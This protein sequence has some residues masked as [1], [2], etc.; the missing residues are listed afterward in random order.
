MEKFSDSISENELLLMRYYNDSL[1]KIK[2]QLLDAAVTGNDTAHLKKLQENV[3]NELIKLN[4]KFQWFSKDTTSKT[5]KKGIKQQETSFR[6]LHIKFTPV[7]ASTYTQFAGIHKQAVK[8]LAINTY[9]PLKRVVDVI[10][11][12][13]IE[14]F[15]RTN[16]N[17]T[18]AILKKLLKFFPDSEDLRSTGLASIQ[19][20]VTGNTTWQRAIREFQET[21]MKEEIFKVP[22]YKKD[23]TLH[24]MVNMADYA[25]LVA[26]T[27]SAEAYRKG[28][29]NA[30]LEAFD[31]GDLVQVNGHSSFPNS[32]CLPFE[33]A[34]LSLTGKTKGYTTL[35]EAKAQGLFHP[36]CIHHFGVTR[37]VI[38]EYDAIEAGKNQGTVLKEIDKPPTAKR[39]KQEAEGNQKWNMKD[40]LATYTGNDELL[41]KAFK[42]AT[43]D[44]EMAEVLANVNKLPAVKIIN[45]RGK[46]YYD[47][48]RSAISAKDEITFLH[49]FG[50]SL[51]YGIIKASTKGYGSFSKKLES[52]VDKHR[53]KRM[54]NF[55]EAVANKFREVKRTAASKYGVEAY[56]HIKEE[57]WNA[58][59]DIFDALTNGNMFGKDFSIAGHGAKY[60][61]MTG[62]KE[63]EI[64]AQYVRLRMNNCT[65]ALSFLKE[66]V[67]DLLK[68]LDESFTLYVKELKKL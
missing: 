30:I 52:V 18:Q 45:D 36:N 56:K 49:E 62:M 54:N 37:A 64:F 59:S 11:R 55:P 5:Y 48:I 26:R 31:E 58:V 10:G 27:T 43:I 20:V 57:G 14:Y 2:K 22:Y 67:P 42:L 61:R 38:A 65:E 46:G 53:I 17:D 9:K 24:S 6:Q 12:D 25:E 3:E 29:E 7:K 13:C 8:T 47:R 44:D 41:E 66:N 35:D 28:A 34:I 16:F 68:S 1:T 39:Q 60:Y 51:D 50:H 33:D 21:F 32:P 63:K 23:G 4:K 15:E 19:G 40:V